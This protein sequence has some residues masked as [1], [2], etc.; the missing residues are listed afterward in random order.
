MTT[1]IPTVGP[2]GIRYRSRLEARWARFFELCRW[3]VAYEPD[4]NL[5][6]WIPDFLVLQGC[7]LLVEIKPE[8][9]LA[10]LVERHQPRI[11]ASGVVAPCLLLGATLAYSGVSSDPFVGAVGMDGMSGTWS[12]KFVPWSKLCCLAG[13]E[14]I[15]FKVAQKFWVRAGN[16][17]QWRPPQ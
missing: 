11:E 15:T 13:A 17:L 8:R 9:S 14:A 1:G 3:P 10:E 12:W 5:R 7:G 6:Q 2:Q 4:M 16:Q